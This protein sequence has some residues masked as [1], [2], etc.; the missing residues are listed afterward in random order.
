M[1]ACGMHKIVVTPCAG[2]L[3]DL[4]GVTVTRTF[5]PAEI[6]Q[7]L[8]AAIEKREDRNAEYRSAAASRSVS[9]YLDA[10]LG[11]TTEGATT[12]GGGAR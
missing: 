5:G 8:G 10:V 9:G 6:A 3:E 12:R 11:G 7:A 1:M 2:D 4:P